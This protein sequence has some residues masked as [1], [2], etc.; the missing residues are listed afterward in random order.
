MSVK[1]RIDWVRMNKHLNVLTHTRH[2]ESPNIVASCVHELDDIL[3]YFMG[4]QWDSV[5]RGIHVEDG[6][7]AR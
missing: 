1:A 2:I 4:V 7:R 5:R 6:T 3:P